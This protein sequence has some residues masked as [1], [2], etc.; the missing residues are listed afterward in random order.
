MTIVLAWWLRYS[1][2]DWKVPSSNPP[3]LVILD[4]QKN[5]SSHGAIYLLQM[6]PS[7]QTQDATD[8]P[9]RMNDATL[10]DVALKMT[11]L[12]TRSP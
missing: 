7:R 5:R 1:F 2:S 12:L 3:S 4:V 8:K 9:S 11:Q 6:Q 10:K